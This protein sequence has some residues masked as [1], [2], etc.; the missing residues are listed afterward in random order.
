MVP[1]TILK[2]YSVQDWPKSHFWT[3]VT[4]TDSL[5]SSSNKISILNG[6]FPGKT[7]GGS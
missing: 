5:I 2:I 4:F 7:F 3:L 6:F 1:Q